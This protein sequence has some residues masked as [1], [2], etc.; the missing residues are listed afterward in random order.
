MIFS[1]FI[2]FSQ[3]PQLTFLF[4]QYRANPSLHKTVTQFGL[5][6]VVIFLRKN[7]KTFGARLRNKLQLWT[8]SKSNLTLDLIL[9]LL[10]YYFHLYSLNLFCYHPFTYHYSPH[11]TTICQ[12]QD[13]LTIL[14]SAGPELSITQHFWS[15]CTASHSRSRDLIS[16]SIMQ[17]LIIG[18][19]YITISSPLAYGGLI[20]NPYF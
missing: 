6:L 16:K 13:V 20:W 7:N 4:I 18:T 15:Q 8:N 1:L 5:K 17:V 14:E 10:Y 2:N 19:A 9:T 11:L 3:I 12:I